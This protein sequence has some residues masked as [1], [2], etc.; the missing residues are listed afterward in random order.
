MEAMKVLLEARLHQRVLPDALIVD[1]LPCAA[2]VASL[3]IL[4][5]AIHVIA[6]IFCVSQCHE[7]LCSLVCLH[8]SLPLP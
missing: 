5:Y 1:A 6:R 2:V 4:N 7:P 3:Q 8:R